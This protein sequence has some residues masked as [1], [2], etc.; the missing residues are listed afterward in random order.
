[1][2]FSIGRGKATGAQGFWRRNLWGWLALAPAAAAFGL[3]ALDRTDFFDQRLNGI[4]RTAISAAPADWVTFSGAKL[5]LVAITA[6]ADLYD[7]DGKPL[8]LPKELKAW[9]SVIDVQVEDQRQLADCELSLEDDA[10]RLFGTRPH[11]LASARIPAPTCTAE[12]KALSTYQV[13]VF[14]I[15]PAEAKPVA[16]RVVSRPALPAYARLI[17][18]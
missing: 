2:K 4:P 5:K 12:D 13:T 18:V 10:G 8:K 11:E 16:I 15:T 6:T 14:F 7:T 3:V 1:M 17:A 9:R